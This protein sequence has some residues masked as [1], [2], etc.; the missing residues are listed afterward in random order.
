M[1]LPP[2]K[3]CRKQIHSI[4]AIEQGHRSVICKN[5]MCPLYM[6]IFNWVEMEKE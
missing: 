3:V 6:R 2:C 5:R 1:N 4:P